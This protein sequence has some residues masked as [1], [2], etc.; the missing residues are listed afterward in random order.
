MQGRK[1]NTC[2]E[3]QSDSELLLLDKVTHS[4]HMRR[5]LNLNIS[6]IMLASG[7]T[8]CIMLETG[9]ERELRMAR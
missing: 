9:G 6:A 2:F 4:S 5:L 1:R 8:N 7:D 3:S